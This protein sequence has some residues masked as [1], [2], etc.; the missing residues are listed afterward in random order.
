MQGLRSRFILAVSAVVLILVAASGAAA[1]VGGPAVIRTITPPGD[2]PFG[3]DYVED[4]YGVG[5]IYHTDNYTGDVYSITTGGHATLLFNVPD[6]LGEP[7]THYRAQGICYV[8]SPD[9]QRSGTLYILEADRGGSPYYTYVYS[10]TMDGTHLNTYDVSDIV[11]RGMGITFDGNH[12][13]VVGNV[14]LVECDMSFNLV[15][16]HTLPWYV[17]QGGLDF[18]P[19][20]YRLYNAPVLGQR[21][22]VFERGAVDY[23]YTW[24]TAIYNVPALAIGHVTRETRTLWIMDNSQVQGVITEIHDDYYDPVESASWGA[25]KALYR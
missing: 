13:W 23:D 25:I 21:V 16:S 5:T 17:G 22:V 18:D 2:S 10:F 24:S 7:Y 14:T 9:D 6:A 3:L 20:T 4:Q 8:G 19:S 12:F 11:D 15:Q 1:P